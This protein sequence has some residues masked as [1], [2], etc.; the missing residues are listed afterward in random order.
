MLYIG[1][2]FLSNCS[3]DQG[4]KAGLVKLLRVQVHWKDHHHQA[5]KAVRFLN[6]AAAQI[7]NSFTIFLEKCLSVI[8]VG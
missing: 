4:K 7:D 5:M 1:N 3:A 2:C 8:D 6:I